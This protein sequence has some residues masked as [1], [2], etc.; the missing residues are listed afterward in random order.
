MTQGSIAD[1]ATEIDAAALLVYRAAWTKDVGATGL[2]AARVT[3][4]SAMAKMFATE[5]AQRVIDRAVQLHGGLGVTK[6]VKVEELYREIRAL[7]IYEGATEV[8]KIVIAREAMKSRAGKTAL[9]AE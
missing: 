6:G 7:R 5:A 9:A 3:G 4:E 8:Q 2:G 1:S